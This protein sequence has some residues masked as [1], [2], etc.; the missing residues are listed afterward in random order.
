MDQQL[1]KGL[2]IVFDGLRPRRILKV[3]TGD[4]VTAR[5]VSRIE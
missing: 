4:M 3:P 2:A 1:Q 5:L